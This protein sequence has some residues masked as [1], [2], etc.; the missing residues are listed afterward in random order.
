MPDSAGICE[1]VTEETSLHIGVRVRDI[2]LSTGD[3]DFLQLLRSSAKSEHGIALVEM[4]ILKL[5]E[6]LF[7]HFVR[8]GRSKLW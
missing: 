2:T 3:R 6:R 5:Y 1:Q 4:Q 7:R 8:V